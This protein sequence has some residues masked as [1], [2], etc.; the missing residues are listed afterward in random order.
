MRESGH[1]AVEP[2]NEDRKESAESAGSEL[3][4]RLWSVISFDECLASNLTYQAAVTEINKYSD[5]NFNGLCIVT[6]RVAA[7]MK[8]G[9]T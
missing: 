7:R 5:K 3:D 1:Y 4:L 6:D 8:K 9:D 2:G